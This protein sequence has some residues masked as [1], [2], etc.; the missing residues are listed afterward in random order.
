[1]NSLHPI[2]HL[3]KTTRGSRSVEIIN[4]SAKL[5]VAQVRNMT[6]GTVVQRSKYKD[7]YGK[8]TI[9]SADYECQRI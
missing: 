7:L 3:A 6:I 2:L 8:K 5:S 4:L 1:M 9:V